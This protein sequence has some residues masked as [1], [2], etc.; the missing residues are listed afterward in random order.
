MAESVAVGTVRQKRIKALAEALNRLSESQLHWTEGIIHQFQQKPTLSRNPE[1]DLINDCVLEMFG[2]ALQI[3]HCLSIEALS[4]DRFEY[5]LDRVLNRCGIPSTLADK[6]NPG[7]DITIRGVPF[8]LKTQAD[9]SIDRDFL[10]ISKFMELGKGKWE[11]E[12]DLIGLRGRFF[13][14]MKAYR[15]ILQLRRLTNKETLQEYELV[16]V[17]K[18]LL[19]KAAT[20]TIKMMHDSKQNPKPGT[21]TVRENGGQVLFELYF[22]GGTER[23]LQIRHL[24]KRACIVHANWGIKRIALNTSPA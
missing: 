18:E 16:E 12:A 8:S 13:T 6:C 5:A 9:K 1:S 11:L 4:K 23:K 19:L 14:H 2:D 3:H 22:D 24:A 15:R 20:G 17:P 21:C 10:H 7:H